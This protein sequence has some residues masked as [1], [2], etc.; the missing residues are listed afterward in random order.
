MLSKKYFKEKIAPIFSKRRNFPIVLIILISFFCGMLGGI[1]GGIYFFNKS[2]N[3]F[4]GLNLQLSQKAAEKETVAEEGRLSAATYE[5]R[6]VAVA[7]EASPSVAS[8]IVI[9][10]VLVDYDPFKE[11]EPFGDE[12]KVPQYQKGE[13][14]KKSVVGG[15]GFIVSEDGMILTN[16]HVVMDKEADYA[17]LTN[18]KKELPAKVLARDPIKDLALLKIESEEKFKPLKLGNSDELQSGQTVIAIGNALGEFQNTV[19][20]GV[21]SGLKREVAAVGGNY[22][23][24][25]KNLIQTDAAINKGNSGGPLL[26]LSGEVIGVNVAMAVQPDAQNIGFAIPINE[27]KKDIEQ[28]KSFGRII[29]PFLGV[30]YT[31]ITE[32]LMEKFDLPVDYGAWIGRSAEGEETETAVFLNSAAGSAGLKRNDIILEFGA[33]KITLENPL[34]KIILEYS[35]GDRV[36]LKI[37]SWGKIKTIPVVLGERSE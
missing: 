15:T 27:A 25:L 2:M 34:A 9:R 30:Y 17:I 10:D 21:I 20:V 32:D 31:L 18:N 33:E 24:I 14:E 12:F 5:E 11:L 29:Y 36:F 28:V 1:F 4:G 37:L 16:K 13:T 6:V 19:S 23:E 8:I 7:K 35:P 22:A 3:L 26:N